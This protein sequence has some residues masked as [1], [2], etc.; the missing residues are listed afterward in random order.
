MTDV[1]TNIDFTTLTNVPASAV[2]V[3]GGTQAV[4]M[5]SFAGA[6]HASTHLPSGSDPITTA[7][8]TDVGTANAEGS[9]ES[10]ARSD[11]THRVTGLFEAGGQ[12]L[13][14]AAIADGDIVGR[15]GNTL[16]PAT[17]VDRTFRTT[18]IFSDSSPIAIGTL[19][20]GAIV[21]LA[22]ISTPIVFDGTATASVGWAGDTTAIFNAYDLTS[23]S[24]GISMEIVAN[25]GGEDLI[26]TYAAGGAAQGSA[27]VT[28]TYSVPA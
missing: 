25:G 26:I 3:V 13:T 23:G 11:H 21:T 20:A 24:G 9:A 4:D 5:S 12:A 18:F 28:I 7:A 1:L 19:P 27:I 17:N 10:L 16:A 8:G 2:S 22:R 14:I 15:V 6:E